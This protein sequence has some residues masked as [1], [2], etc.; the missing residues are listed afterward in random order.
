MAIALYACSRPYKKRSLIF[1]RQR[2]KARRS[3]Y[4][5]ILGHIKK[6]S[7]IFFRKGNK[8]QP[9]LYMPVLGHIKS[10]VYYLVDKE[11]RQD[12]WLYK[13]G[14][15]ALQKSSPQRNK[16]TSGQAW[17]QNLAS[18]FCV[19]K[20]SVTTPA[21]NHQSTRYKVW[22]CSLMAQVP[23]RKWHTSTKWVLLKKMLE[24]CCC[25]ILLEIAFVKF[26]L[27]FWCAHILHTPTNSWSINMQTWTIL[28]HEYRSLV[29]ACSKQIHP[30]V[31]HFPHYK[32]S[33]L[34][35]NTTKT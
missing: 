12:L 24:K 31:F 20:C 19:Y 30:V 21:I 25:G 16:L 10:E 2:N 28:V 7:L 4:M 8:P 9:Y 6:R 22:P 23:T 11:K 32:R 18:A 15:A 33:T 29:W 13:A 27:N 14:I 3:L 17:K 34:D 5:P 35:E 1:F 26:T